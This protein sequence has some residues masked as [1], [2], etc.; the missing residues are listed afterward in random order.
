[1]Y[2]TLALKMKLQLQYIDNGVI[3]LYIIIITQ[4]LNKINFSFNIYQDIK[5]VITFWTHEI[6]GFLYKI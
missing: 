5:P 4:S 1:M 3:G 6:G 2:T